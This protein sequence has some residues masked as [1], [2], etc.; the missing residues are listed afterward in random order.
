M[1]LVCSVAPIVEIK[2]DP[3]RSNPRQVANF[4]LL[5]LNNSSLKFA[6]ERYFVKI[7]VVAEFML[8]LFFPF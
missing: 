4:K 7:L 8:Q 5:S 2:F 3:S 1:L 6:N